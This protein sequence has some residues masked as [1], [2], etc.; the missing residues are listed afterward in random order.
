MASKRSIHVVG[1]GIIGEPCLDPEHYAS[2]LQVV[3]PYLFD[4]V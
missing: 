1:T 3:K 4:E 2:C